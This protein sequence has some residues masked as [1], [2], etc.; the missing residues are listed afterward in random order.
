MTCT[1]TCSYITVPKN[2][3]GILLIAAIVLTQNSVFPQ[4]CFF[5]QTTRGLLIGVSEANFHYPFA[6]NYG[7]F[8]LSTRKI[9]SSIFHSVCT[10]V[11][12][13]SECLVSSVDGSP[14]KEIDFCND[15]KKDFDSDWRP[16]LRDRLFVLFIVQPS[17]T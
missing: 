1:A 14:N 3:M 5:T 16:I 11:P 8:G 6:Q 4:H 7:L 12:S 2:N 17:H 9:L 15:L 10:I 13:M